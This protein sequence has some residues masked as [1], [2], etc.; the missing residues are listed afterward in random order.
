MGGVVNA[1]PESKPWGTSRLVYLDGE[2]QVARISVVPGGYCSKHLHRWKSN[3]FVVLSG[4]LIVNVQTESGE[5]A[6]LC[7][8]GVP[9][10]VPDEVKHWF[11]ARTKVEAIEVYHATGSGAVDPRDIARF[12]EGGVSVNAGT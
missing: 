10:T 8:P 3:T 9:L 4:E 7:Q 2:V 5:I 12:S 11:H 1:E 6:V